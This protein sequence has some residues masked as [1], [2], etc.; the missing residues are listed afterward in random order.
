MNRTKSLL[1]ALIASLVLGGLAC[2]QGDDN[3]NEWK[4][5]KPGADGCTGP[6]GTSGSSGIGGG[7]GTTG[8][9]GT[10]DS[11]AGA[12]GTSTGGTA[13]SSGNA[14]NGGNSG[15]GGTAG[16]ST[17]GTGGGAGTG[18]TAGSGGTGGSSGTGGTAGN[19]GFSGT[20]GIS[21]SGG[22]AGIGGNAGVGGTAGNAGTSGIGGSSGTG[23]TS[24]TGGSA[25]TGGTGAGG[26]G[27]TGGCSTGTTD[28]GGICFNLQADDTHCGD[29]NNACQ[30]G[31]S[32]K[33]GSCH[34]TCPVNVPGQDWDICIV[35]GVET[36][37]NVL[38][39][40]AHCGDCA[41]ACSSGQFCVA[42]SCTAT[43]TPS[44]EVCDGFDN[45]CNGK[46][47]EGCVCIPNLELSCNTGLNGV[48]G[49]GMHTCAP[50]GMSWGP[51]L[52]NQPP[53]ATEI[54]GDGYDNDCN[55][56]VDDTCVCTAATTLP[57]DTTLKGICAEGTKT[58]NADG[59]SWGACVQN[60]Q[61][62]AAEVCNNGLDDDC[63][64]GVDDGC[65]CVPNLTAP[66]STNLP[67][68]CAPGTHTCASD[69]L[70]WSACT[71]N[72]QPIPE[73]CYDGLDND[74][75]NGVDNGCICTPSATNPC[76]T[77]LKGV[78][79]AGTSTCAA[80]GKSWGN[81]I[82]NVQP[83]ATEVC[84][85]GLDDDCKNGVDDGCPCTPNL[86][87]PC[88][89]GLKGVC[90]PGTHTCAV[91]G[92]SWGN[93]IQN[94]Q[95]A[96]TEICNN[97]LDD[98]CKNGVDDG[99]SCTPNLVQP[100]NTNLLGVCAAGTHTCAADGL[101]WSA[102]VQ[103]TQPSPEVCGD[104]LDNNCQNGVD[105][106]CV[107]PPSTILPCDTTLKG[108]CAAGTKTCA[109]DGKSWGACVQNTQ[110]AAQEICNNGLDDDCKNGVD[111]GCTCTP[112][113]VQPCNTS[114]FGV[115]AAGTHT[116]N[117]AGTAW[118]ACV[119][120]TQPSP[121]VCGDGLD[122]NCQNGVDDGCVC[123][124]STT[125]P[126]DTTLKGV[127]AAGTKTCAVDGKSW[128]AC[129]Q[130]VQPAA[131]E[132]CNDGL[133]N[134][135]SGAVDEGCP[136]T[137]NLTQPCNTGLF[138]VC[139]AGTHTCNAAGTAWSACVQT[140]QPSPE[141]CGDG[142]DNNCQN[143]V[144]DGCVC[145]PSTTLPCDTTLKGVCAAGTKTCAV[146]GK[147]WGAC[148]QNVQA[149]AT[150]VCNDGLDNNCSGA[151]DEGC[152]CT[153][154]LVQPCNTGLFGV[155]AAGTHMCNAA[156]TAWGSCIQ[157]NGAVTEICGDN[158]DNDCNNQIDNGCT[159]VANTTQPCS[160]GFPGIC[161]AG[162]QTCNP[163][164]TAWGACVQDKPAA[165]QE[166]C[167]N[168]LDD[169]CNGLLDETPC[170]GNGNSGNV[171]VTSVGCSQVLDIRSGNIIAASSVPNAAGNTTCFAAGFSVLEQSGD[172]L[173][174]WGPQA[175]S[176]T[177]TLSPIFVEARCSM[178]S[179]NGLLAPGWAGLAGD[180]N[181]VNY[182]VVNNSAAPP[183]YAYSLGAS[184]G[185][186]GYVYKIHF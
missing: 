105:D 131:S 125:L 91:D 5:W 69:G 43:C 57:C 137:P 140:T 121:E 163:A 119:Q 81:C 108:V 147:S 159:C 170:T 47:D 167:N 166:I 59:K 27:G 36:C 34:I 155:C 150:E 101:S 97:G 146:D 169:N 180:Y 61:P 148:V 103:N 116:C 76:D 104:G 21:G 176:F 152:T 53:A 135:C 132:V 58:C 110:P 138:G 38:G 106:G 82:Q 136:C 181:L 73:I 45:N 156:G 113:L 111:D 144:D 44:P 133:D 165:A 102:C 124:A 78:C 115:C 71:Q 173:V 56:D 164:G 107:C 184:C 123:P 51:C 84:N 93:C 175:M 114:L 80:D 179:Y 67:G 1:A 90:A 95:A 24:G 83:A 31:T 117:A 11:A 70:S 141:V 129:V 60:K 92:K 23:G 178:S 16:T 28:C 172:I 33:F 2:S 153:P 14:G 32:C 177:T 9:S 161:S 29:C 17:G 20:G 154:N 10:P 41:K 185:T 64:N 182:T 151:V 68:V 143:G 55:G 39:D 26:T 50:D 126:C 100:C 79:A 54:C 134:N 96:A 85:N 168:F 86:T 37:I 13:G 25:G 87:L 157:N 12:G 98:D 3:T 46:T 149:L 171:T 118:S 65:T 94:V 127:C 42:G 7:A 162:T 109:V 66:C 142:L 130:N 75:Q 22:T 122:N 48:C 62:L 158:L 89:T 35:S 139:A 74:C 52:S 112:N 128:G 145:P 174:V 6:S 186:L 99:C 8:D 63:K 4:C 15:I 49:A 183:N 18:G 30:T 120:T 160:T 40:A 77:T 88:N 19:G 72:I